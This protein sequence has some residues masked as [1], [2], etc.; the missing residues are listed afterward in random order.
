MSK[1]SIYRSSAGSGKTYTLVKEY[2]KLVLNDPEAF[3]NVLAVTFTNKS[4]GE[5]KSRIIDALRK[6]SRG[7]EAELKKNL[8]ND[9]VKGNIETLSAVVLKN[10]LH[11]YSY[12]SVST[13]DSFF[14]KVIRSFAR[15]LKLQLGYNIELDQQAILE[16]ITDKLLDD[17]GINTELTA[18]LEDFI[19]YSIDDEKGWKIDLKI[20][21]LAREI[22][23]ERYMT[24]HGSEVHPPGKSKLREFIGILFAVK[25]D[26]ESTM[27]TIA[28]KSS[29]MLDE[30]SLTIDDFPFKKN[31]FMNYLLNNIVKGKFE[32]GQRAREASEDINKWTGKSSKP[33]VKAAAEAGLFKLLVLAVENYDSNFLKY[34]TASQLIKTIYITGIFSDLTDKLKKYRDDNNVLLI[35]D[36]NNILLNV[37]SGDSSPFIYEKI[38]SFYKNFLID[39]F[40][41]TSTFQWRNFFPLIENSLSENNASLIVGDVKQS[42]YRWRNGNMKL[43]LE[44]VKNDLAGF[45]EFIREE[46][47]KVNYRS[48]KRIVE[49]NNAFFK[50]ASE[51]C[52]GQA[53]EEESAVIAKAFGD[54][55]QQPADN[56]EEGYINIKFYSDD[57]DA[58]VTSRELSIA[59]MITDIKQLLQSGYCQK[60]IMVLVRNN[61]DAAEAA[62]SLIDSRL[63]VVSSD[64]LLLT[65]SPKVR[66]LLN[67]FRYLIDNNDLIAKT[68]IL[69]NLLVYIK[70]EDTVLNEIFTDHFIYDTDSSLFKKHL[71]AGFFESSTGVLVNRKL[72]GLR[73]Y[74]L[75]EEL[76]MLFGLYDS[77]DTY[78]I[79]F[80]DVLKKYS[81]ENNSDVYGFVN[82]WEENKQD[83]TII[84]PDEED[85]VR[86]MTI[87]KAK[88][89]QAPVVF[90]PFANWE[91]GL[92][93]NRN[94][95]WVSSDRKPFDALPAYFVKASSSLKDTYF[96][97]DYN[98]ESVLTFLDNLNLM[99]VAFTRA[100]EKLYIGVPGKRK[101][102]FSAAKVIYETL[103]NSPILAESYD[104]ANHRYEYGSAAQQSRSNKRKNVYESYKIT[105]MVSGNIFDKIV[106][107]PEFE[108]YVP[109]TGTK[110]KQLKNR[111]II[112]HK[113]L[114]LLNNS[115]DT[116]IER[117]SKKLVSLGI[118]TEEQKAELAAEL[119][120]IFGI[121][122]VK[123]WFDSPNAMNEREIILPDGS[124]YR[125]DKV[126]LN[127]DEAV[128]VDYK[129]GG[130]RSEHAEQIKMYGG[131]L[132]NMGF[133]KV[134][135]NLFYINDLKIETLK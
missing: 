36:I 118:I 41:D 7:Q 1:F 122:K 79:R 63:K 108:D 19:F 71:P 8:E 105:Q 29:E 110:I 11:K 131:I 34:N 121:S 88:G 100:E 60:D 126:I 16:K 30:Y 62:H 35:S 99:Y 40:Q 46:T 23:S 61:S 3:K 107:K 52:S 10:I 9:G 89:L 81:L 65:N 128:V 27:K 114:S 76:I 26:F 43:L 95:I 22:F 53:P 83:N 130:K 4:A 47:L 57:T 69:Y 55:S 44:E 134:E 109:E 120:K 73:L 124:I 59:A 42:I 67:I 78:L 58:G 116:E 2:L 87:H 13:I 38:G 75:A 86:V 32:P 50:T 24:R 125:P 18:F 127:D 39:E 102:S 133:K 17:S 49:F 51:I 112:I 33:A 104:A 84:V 82:W 31:G 74:D 113:A 14:H 111:G 37:I 68:E 48:K 93:A 70:H 21:D 15:E 12:F 106:V 115:T 80:L 5:M 92:S 20:K 77:A 66:L 85:A 45:D 6:L 25:N 101:D 98:E 129:S 94:M 103:T 64:S 96:A 123:K 56:S 91:F 54:I 119:Q 28:G 97:R 90:I 117:A 132:G 135:M 72:S